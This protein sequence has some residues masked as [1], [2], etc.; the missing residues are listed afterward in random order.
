M[1]RQII[2][3]LDFL[4]DAADASANARK[5]CGELVQKAA[6]GVATEHDWEGS[7]VPATSV[8]S[9]ARE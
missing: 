5:A 6:T 8:T 3:E 1:S 9:Y 4:R 7:C 2:F